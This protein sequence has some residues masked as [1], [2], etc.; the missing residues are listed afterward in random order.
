[1]LKWILIF[2]VAVGLAA[3]GCS[4]A[5]DSAESGQTAWLTRTPTPQSDYA[6]A[7]IEATIDKLVVELNK[8][9]Q[10]VGV[11]SAFVPKQLD[12][13]F[14]VT[15][16]GANR[17]YAEL[18]MLGNVVA[19]SPSEEEDSQ[20]LQKGIIDN[21]LKEGVLLIGLATVSDVVHP[22]ID[23]VVDAGGTV[24]TFDSDAVDT[25]RQLY[26]GTINVE[27]GKTAGTTL[28]NIIGTG[29]TGTVVVF[30]YDD[31][32]WRDGYDRTH[33]ARK[34][35]E[36]AGH[37]VVIRHVDWGNAQANVD[38]IQEQLTNADPPAVGCLGVFNNS[39]ACADAVVA[40]G[41][42]SQV[43]VVAFDT[44][45]QTVE[46][47]Q[48]GVIQA[49]H[50]QRQYYMGYLVPYLLMAINKLGLE[51]TKALL[52]DIMVDGNRIDTGL[53]VI[54]A[55]GIAAYKEFQNQLSAL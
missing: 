4:D 12:A 11:K 37:T 18:Q 30:G 22:S 35:L 54:P 40:A 16:L 26:V 38:F 28:N 6:P 24:I 48:Q 17:A 42:Q 43:K 25:K 14:E 19:P 32:N 44:E 47:M 7:S 21:Q 36:A 34:V 55:D 53:D 51:P 23:A 27:A 29:K 15:V 46:Y 41:L 52:G 31:V 1:M 50:V 8:T 45:T 3:A 10:S 13:F 9:E 39:F 49:T 20:Q 5:N 33:E 2:T